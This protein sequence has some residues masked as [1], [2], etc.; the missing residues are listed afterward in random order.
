MK[1][2]LGCKFTRI[3]PDKKDFD[4][5]IE[6]GKIHNHII[7]STRKSTKKSTKKSLVDNISK[8]FPSV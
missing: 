5:F 6:N 1:E 2:E 3:N 7:K 4:I 8:I